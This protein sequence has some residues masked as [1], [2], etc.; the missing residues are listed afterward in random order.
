MERHHIEFYSPVEIK[1]VQGKEA[2]LIRKK[3]QTDKKREEQ[4]NKALLLKKQA[5][6]DEFYR[7]LVGTN[8]SAIL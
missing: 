3:D 4:T 2:N 1:F 5:A 8:F 7:K 6:E